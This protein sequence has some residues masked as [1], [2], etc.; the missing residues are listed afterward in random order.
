MKQPH[1]MLAPVLLALAAASPTALAAP[2]ARAPVERKAQE[3]LDQWK[4]R[5]DREGF[6]YTVAGPF[7]IAGDGSPAQIAR[8]RDR[9]ILAAARALRATYFDR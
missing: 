7:V 9:T 4:R 6:S 1:L 3:L 2:S 5:F 8:Y